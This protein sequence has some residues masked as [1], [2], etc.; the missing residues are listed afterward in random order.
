MLSHKIIRAGTREHV[1]VREG[2]GWAAEV[3]T[4]IL[5][6]GQQGGRRPQYTTQDGTTGSPGAGVLPSP[7]T[8]LS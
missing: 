3:S 8:A 4:G 5:E 6:V 2:R 1:G 7:E